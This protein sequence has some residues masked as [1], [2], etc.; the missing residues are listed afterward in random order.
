M[1]SPMKCNYSENLNTIYS[2]GSLKS[3]KEEN[4]AELKY[5]LR[6]RYFEKIV[7]ATTTLMFPKVTASSF[8][9]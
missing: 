7:Q 6:G 5:R 1:Q 4:Q 9:T 8:F 3:S 2:I